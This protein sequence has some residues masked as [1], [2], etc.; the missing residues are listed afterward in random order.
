MVQTI[1]DYIR[2]GSIDVNATQYT[3]V[4]ILDWIIKNG[5]KYGI[6]LA[7]KTSS[8]DVQWW[9]FIY[10]ASVIPKP[11][12][13]VVAPV[14]A[15]TKP[16]E[17]VKKSE[18]LTPEQL[19]VDDYIRDY[20]I[21]FFTETLDV[22]DIDVKFKNDTNY[23]VEFATDKQLQKRKDYLSERISS[24]HDIPDWFNKPAFHPSY[25]TLRQEEERFSFE[26]RKINS[27]LESRIL[28]RL[29][30]TFSNPIQ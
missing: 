13:V 9:H 3:Q 7:G 2:R 6:K 23:L 25:E 14:V 16:V 21:S 10:D 27:E 22:D 26:Y 29:E 11:E 1:K 8:G 12:P 5:V 24:I 28:S 19:L 4:E 15:E 18:K 17:E 30:G 20:N